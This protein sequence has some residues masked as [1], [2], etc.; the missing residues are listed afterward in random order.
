MHAKLHFTKFIV[1]QCRLCQNITLGQGFLTM[2]NNNTALLKHGRIQIMDM[3]KAVYIYCTVL[4]R[5]IVSVGTALSS[6]NKIHHEL[7][8]F[9]FSTSI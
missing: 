2:Q 6:F 8:R 5:Y 3:L 7:G 4:Y 1:G 9:R